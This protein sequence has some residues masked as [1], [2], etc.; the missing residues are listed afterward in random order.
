ML[1][2]Q[3]QLEFLGEALLDF[4][5]PRDL[6]N[7]LTSHQAL[8]NSGSKK[9]TKPLKANGMAHTNSNDGVTKI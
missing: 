8:G 6:V 9:D 7:W 1:F 4:S 3:A 5:K 2:S